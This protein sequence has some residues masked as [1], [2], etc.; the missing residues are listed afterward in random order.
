MG[1]VVILDSVSVLFLDGKQFLGP[2]IQSPAIIAVT[3]AAY[4]ATC[5]AAVYC[6]VLLARIWRP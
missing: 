4:L 3:A 2:D 5:C 1:F 6:S